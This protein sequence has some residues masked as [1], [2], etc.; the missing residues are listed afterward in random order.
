MSVMTSEKVMLNVRVSSEVM[1]RLDAKIEQAKRS[2]HR[3]TKERLVSDAILS[4]YPAAIQN[5][6]WLPSHEATWVAGADPYCN[7]ALLDF[8][9][10]AEVPR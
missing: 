1:G 10:N 3:M 4:A 7:A 5:T 6:D 2:G 8:M 9:D